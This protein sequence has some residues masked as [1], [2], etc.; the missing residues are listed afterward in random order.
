MHH[1]VPVLSLQK[2]YGFKV[3]LKLEGICT[4]V[5]CYQTGTLQANLKYLLLLMQFDRYT[6]AENIERVVARAQLWK[7]DLRAE[8]SDESYQY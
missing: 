8:G 2:H 4:V 3:F 6:I 5:S 1:D 7:N